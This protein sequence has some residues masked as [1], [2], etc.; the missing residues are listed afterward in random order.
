M[1]E[2]VASENSEP[3]ED[4]VFTSGATGAVAS[5]SAIPALDMSF[6]QSAVFIPRQTRSV[7]ITVVGCGGTGSWIA[8][9]VAR[10]G[11]VLIE[12]GRRVRIVFVDPDR[13]SAANVP[14]SCFCEGEIGELKAV[15][16]A[17]RYSGAWSLEIG[18]ITE[19]FT[20]EMVRAATDE[21]VLKVVVGCVDTAAARG[22]LAEVL[23]RRTPYGYYDYGSRGQT[24]LIDCGNTREGGQVLV[25]SATRLEEM[26]ESFK[27]RS[28]CT[29]LPSPMWQH[30]ELLEELEE[31]RPDHHLSCV[32]LMRR[33]AQSLMVNHFVASIAGDYLVRLLVTRNLRRYAT[34]FDMEACS[35]RNKYITPETIAQT[36]GQEPALLMAKMGANFLS[37]DNEG[38]GDYLDEMEEADDDPND[39]AA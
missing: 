6:R 28:I 31:E 12:Q 37:V 10:I 15:A 3:G 14:R 19:G 39:A 13:V 29:Q 25:G 7:R 36:V 33:N 32:E 9:Q 17:R 4:G 11:R 16:L 8:A 34:Y 30:P 23:V 2:Q 27:G 35:T 22:A 26:R 1:K 38:D 5:S 24:I 18:A 21:D 20:P